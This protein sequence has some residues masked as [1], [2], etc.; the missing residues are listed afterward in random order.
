MCPV[1]ETRQRKRDS[2][3]KSRAKSVLRS[4]D[5]VLHSTGS[6][7]VVQLFK[8]KRRKPADTRSGDIYQQVTALRELL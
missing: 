6:P 5:S 8:P 7:K 1:E 4:T 2:V 3:K